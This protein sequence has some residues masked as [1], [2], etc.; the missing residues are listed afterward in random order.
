MGYPNL[1]SD[2][3]GDANWGS[4]ALH[5]GRNEGIENA[6]KCIKGIKS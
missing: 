6:L 1:Q 3:L 2:W 5:S 4:W